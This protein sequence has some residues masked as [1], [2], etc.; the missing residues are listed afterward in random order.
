VLPTFVPTAP[1]TP[2]P[3]LPPTL[4]PPPT[5]TPQPTPT[6]LPPTLSGGSAAPGA[7][8]PVLGT[9]WTAGAAITITWPDGSQVGGA[10]VQ[11]DGRFATLI[12]VPATALPGTTYTITARGGGL[13]ATADVTA[14]IVYTPSI[15]LLNT[16]PPRAAASVG[17]TGTGWP[18]SRNYS[19]YFDGGT[20]AVSGGVTSTTGTFQGSFTVPANT[21]PGQHTVTAMSA[22][23]SVNAVLTTQ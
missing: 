5:P 19:I 8:L 2:L 7:T 9:N 22:G 13:T 16:F 10:D 4:P 23:Y 21:V 6:P 12:R 14:A 11:A 17:Y 20:T 3:T 15:T 1:P 18:P